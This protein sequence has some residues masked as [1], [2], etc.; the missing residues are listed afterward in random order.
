MQSS[1]RSNRAVDERVQVAIRSA[2]QKV[3]ESLTTVLHSGEKMTKQVEEIKDALLQ[4]KV[5]G[6]ANEPRCMPFIIAFALNLCSSGGDVWKL[7]KVQ[8]VSWK[9]LQGDGRL[10]GT[11]HCRRYSGVFITAPYSYHRS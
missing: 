3:E 9:L 1:F 7:S 5:R 11:C 6:L 4:D 8:D 10:V 2:L